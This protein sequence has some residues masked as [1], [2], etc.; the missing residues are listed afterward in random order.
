LIARTVKYDTL[1]DWKWLSETYA[2]REDPE[3]RARLLLYRKRGNIPASRSVRPYQDALIDELGVSQ[4]QAES[5]MRGVALEAI[6]RRPVDYVQGSLLFTGQ[7]V[8]GEQEPLRGHWKQRAN[9]DWAEQWDNRIDHL[10]APVTPQ[11]TDAQPLATALT[12]FYQPSRAGW[13]LAALFL[14]GCLLVWRQPTRRPALLLAVIAM[15]LL[16]A[17]AFLDGPVQR[18][19]HPVDPLLTIIAAGGLVGAL[20]QLLA[21]LRRATA[22]RGRLED[23]PVVATR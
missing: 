2:G 9:K 11:Q 17:S 16:G 5:L 8:L 3:G 14:F 12:D 10:V 6:A 15:T 1:F 22:P 23:R 13:L 4:A 21:H 19:R 18:Y 7:V 20:S